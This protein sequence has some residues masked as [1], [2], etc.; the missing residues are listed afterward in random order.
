MT[1]KEPERKFRLLQALRSIFSAMDEVHRD[2]LTE[3][4]AYEL[5]EL[6]NL[7]VLLLIGSFAGVP[8][9]PSFLA[10]ELLPHLEHE[11]QVLDARARDA[12]DAL[13]ELTGTLDIK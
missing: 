7:F 9:P 6:E 10:I 3:L 1:S 11:L 4:T 8:F 12:S 5:R 2:R 13:A